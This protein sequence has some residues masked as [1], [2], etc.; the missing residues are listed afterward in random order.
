MYKNIQRL[1]RTSFPFTRKLSRC[2]TCLNNATISHGIKTV[3]GPGFRPNIM[4]NTAGSSSFPLHSTIRQSTSVSRRSIG[5][6]VLDDST[7]DSTTEP[8]D[9]K[10]EIPDVSLV[11]P[12]SLQKIDRKFIDLT[13]IPPEPIKAFRDL[14][15]QIGQSKDSRDHER[16]L[17][18]YRSLADDIDLLLQL[19]PIDFMIAMNSC[20]DLL[21]MIPRMKRI[22]QDVGKT[23]HAHIPEI[24]DI[25]LKAY[26]KMSDFRSCEN[27]LDKM[28][29]QGIEFNT[30]T[31]HIILDICKHQKKYKD[32]RG[33]LAQ[34]RK[35]NVE[36]TSV[37]YLILLANCVKWKNARQAKE[38]FDEMP[39][40][41]LEIEV[42]HYNALLNAYSHARDL[43]GAKQV[44]RMMEDDG[45]PPDQYTYTAMIK[46]LVGSRRQSEAVALVKEMRDHG[47]E[48][49]V[50][51]L[52]AI[53]RAPLEIVEECRQNEVE[54]T[55][56]ESN[57][58]IIRALKSNQFNQVP[59]LMENLQ[60]A[61][62][63]PNVFTFTAMIDADLKMGKYPEAKE[64]FQ[65]MQQ[66]NI[67]PDVIAYSAMISGALK[68]VGVQESMSILKAM[69]DDGLLPNLHTFNSLLSASVGEI[70][71]EGFKTIRDTMQALKVRPD[72]RSFNALLSAYALQ[73]DMEE[74]LKT[75]KDMKQSR[76][77]PD[78]LTY[79][80]LISGYLQ[81]GDLR[82]AMEW[83]YKM[84]EG[85]HVPATLVVNNLMA[86]LHGSGQGQQVM[87]LWREMDHLGMKKNEQS[88]E[89][90]LEACEKF[91]LHEAQSRIEEELQRFL[92][93]ST[94]K[95]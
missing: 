91:G 14:Y 54:M 49:N 43:E 19:Q 24:H 62:H 9:I 78:A 71:V 85:G 1:T 51:V 40:L 77:Q 42:A 63:R 69:I 25:L 31:Y 2:S 72:W 61:G 12:L 8:L 5:T 30:T 13:I 38:Y 29:K 46:A 67:Q 32:A 68:Q 11:A 59:S 16:F 50:K 95:R 22:L 20:R 15:E 82:F 37:T 90:A 74:M 34:M 88:F 52:T 26:V 84:I 53:G 83:Y 39:L 45:I 60:K 75:L 93:R 89:I 10:T 41:G 47:V 6:A 28:K 76:V 70:G 57:Y 64:V 3:Q 87:M 58:L 48:P 27:M 66:A 79:S 55:Q 56:S 65:A 44:F 86:A 36:V 94:S 80:I 92:G 17:S 35:K 73:G 4:V 18:V 81:N 23:S 21:H 33:V 7:E